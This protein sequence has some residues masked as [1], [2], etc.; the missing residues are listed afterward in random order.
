M[1]MWPKTILPSAVAGPTAAKALQWSGLW[2][3]VWRTLA[4]QALQAGR[5]GVEGRVERHDFGPGS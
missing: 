2:R 5:V 4:A 3:A 1:V